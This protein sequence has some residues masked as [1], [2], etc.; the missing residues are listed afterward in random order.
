MRLGEIHLRDPFVWT[1]N[2]IG[3]YYMYGTNGSTAWDGKP[4]GFDAY[5]S[6][7]L[8]DW[9]GPFPVFRPPADFWADQHYWAPEVHLYQGKYYMFA[10]FKA[11]GMC[12]ATQILVADHPLGPF[13]PHG[14]G[15]I[16]PPEW[17]C[18]DGTLFVDNDGAPW[19]V[20]CHEWTQVKD[21]EIRSIR[22][23]QE[24]NGVLGESVLLFKA[25]EA[26]WPVEAEGAGNFVT[27]G[28]FLVRPDDGR[29]LMM[30]S[31]HGKE[32]YAIGIAR[33]LTGGI[34]GPWVQEPELLFEKDGGHGMLFL[35]LDGQ[36][37]MSLHMPNTHPNERPIFFPIRSSDGMFQVMDRKKLET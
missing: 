31:S 34:L 32:G 23:T 7:N 25:S 22:L 10:S 33:S 13:V 4:I 2:H 5:T 16:T 35:T 12:R 18:L 29:L 37:L 30:W 8:T 20:F 1:D 6:S 14:D 36:L 24:L 27:D 3:C 26:S 11:E 17:E 19:M 15:P 28:P 21:G 9:E